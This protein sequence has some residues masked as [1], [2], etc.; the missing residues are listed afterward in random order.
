MRQ[1]SKFFNDTRQHIKF[2]TSVVRDNKP[3]HVSLSSGKY[4]EINDTMQ[5]L[6]AD[7]ENTPSGG[8]IYPNRRL[9]LTSKRQIIF[10]FNLENLLIETEKTRYKKTDKEG[11]TLSQYFLS[12]KIHVTSREI[13]LLAY[14]IGAYEAEKSHTNY[15]ESQVGQIFGLIQEW[16][17]YDEYNLTPVTSILKDTFEVILSALEQNKVHNIKQVSELIAPYIYKMN[18]NTTPVKKNLA[19]PNLDIE[20]IKNPVYPARVGKI[21]I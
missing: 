6:F 5:K 2:I 10:R 13:L 3:E 15:I 11:I 20:Y 7:W 9:I 16:S 1:N 12:K 18:L 8:L 14:G 21:V 19:T 4:R 17:N